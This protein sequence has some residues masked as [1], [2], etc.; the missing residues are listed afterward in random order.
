MKFRSKL[1]YANVM[2]TL[3]LFVALG[4]TSYAAATGSIDS[5]E[6]KNN[7]IRGK[8]IRRG[9][10]QSSDV[11]NGSL[12]SGDF[13]AGE[14]PAGAT[15]LRGL[16][17]VQGVPGQD[18]TDGTNGTNGATNVTV[19]TADSAAGWTAGGSEQPARTCNPGEKA[20]G[21]GV[22]TFNH[23]DFSDVAIANLNPQGSPPTGYQA[24]VN[25]AIAD[26][27]AITRIKVICA[28]P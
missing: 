20:V 5:R 14:L 21:A 4:G 15:G 23:T 26:G 22:E 27:D 24:I 25:T 12:L 6:I 28:A 19:R 7:T 3:A 9:A 16:R 1:S 18:G 8:D 10:V 11:K 13:R 2:A 17:G